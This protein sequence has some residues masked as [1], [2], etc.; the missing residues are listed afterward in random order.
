MVQLDALFIQRASYKL[1]LSKDEGS[2]IFLQG[3][4]LYIGTCALECAL[5]MLATLGDYHNSCNTMHLL[6]SSC[7]GGGGR[8][9]TNSVQTP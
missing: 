3:F 7:G 2:D 4:P 5:Y 8:G 1:H 6:Q 9:G